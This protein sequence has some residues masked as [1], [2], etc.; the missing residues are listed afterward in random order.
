MAEPLR[1]AVGP[2]E[3]YASLEPHGPLEHM[4]QDIDER[5][6]FRE[7][8]TR[9]QDPNTSNFVLDFGNEDAFCATDLTKDYFKTLFSK[10]VST[11]SAFRYMYKTLIS[12]IQR[13]QCFGTRWMYARPRIR[14]KTTNSG[15]KLMLIVVTSGHL[16]NRRKLSKYASISKN[17]T[18]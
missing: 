1:E 11:Y 9:L 2:R 6:N 13:P 18:W 12:S 16:K 7:Y 15:A 14:A 10:P 17:G 3:F 5:A 8:M 4:F